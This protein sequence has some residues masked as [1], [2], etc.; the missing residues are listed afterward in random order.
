ME[1]FAAAA[2]HDIGTNIGLLKCKLERLARD[3]DAVELAI[4]YRPLLALIQECCSRIDLR[5]SVLTVDDFFTG[6]R[7]G[8]TVDQM[9]S[10]VAQL[11]DVI[12]H[13]MQI[14]TFF[15]M[16]ADQADF[17][18]QEVLFGEDVNARFPS[19]QYDMVEAGNCYA[20]G[21]G[22]A[23]VFHLM[24]VMEIGVQRLGAKLGVPLVEETNWQ[25]ILDRVNSAINT[26]PAKDAAT[27]EISQVSANLYAVKLAWRNEVMHPKGIYTLEEAKELI[28]LVKQFMGQLASI[29]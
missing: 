15:Y 13:E 22:T 27:V 12:R 8:M 17:Y 14:C 10:S 1:K 18:S 3:L 4:A 11:N 28:G 2:F 7:H 20:M 19:V 23:C 6:L 25:V 16:P 21:R 9:R 5:I 24:R 29:I 26:L